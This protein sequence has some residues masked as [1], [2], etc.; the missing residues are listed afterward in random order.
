MLKWRRKLVNICMAISHYQDWRTAILRIPAK[1]SCL[2]LLCLQLC[3]SRCKSL[4]NR[5][6][7]QAPSGIDAR[8]Q[9]LRKD[10]SWTRCR[11]ACSFNG[12]LSC[13]RCTHAL[14]RRPLSFRLFLRTL[15]LEVSATRTFQTLLSLQ[16]LLSGL[17]D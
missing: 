4:G 3:P 5:V 8:R 17:R 15:S 7:L 12:P 6:K 9:I 1:V 11:P 13:T 16:V 14:Y 2:S 10:C